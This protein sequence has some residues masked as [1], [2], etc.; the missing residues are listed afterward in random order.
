[1]KQIALVIYHSSNG[2]DNWTPV[3][4]DSVPEWVKEPEVMGRLVAGEQ[5]MDAKQGDRG[6]D[7][8][9]AKRIVSVEDRAMIEGAFQTIQ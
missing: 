8:Y 6:S 7:W 3:M 5:C 4:F 1:M 9:M 2:R